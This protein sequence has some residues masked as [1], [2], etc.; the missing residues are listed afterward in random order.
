MKSRVLMIVGITI[1]LII[2]IIAYQWQRIQNNVWIGGEDYCGD[3]CDQEELRSMGCNNIILKHIFDSTNVFAKGIDGKFYSNL[4]GLPEGVTDEKYTQCVDEII[5][6]RMG[7]VHT[8]PFSMTQEDIDNQ[9]H[10]DPIYREYQGEQI[11]DL[12][13]MIAEDEN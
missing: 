3:Y 8:L 1:P 11:L 10:I 13:A 5:Q 4:E 7:T 6:Q 9:K 2:L 12:D